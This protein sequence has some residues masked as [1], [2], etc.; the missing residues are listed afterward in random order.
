MEDNI[1][2]M[3]QKVSKEVDDFIENARKKGEFDPQD[4]QEVSHKVFETFKKAGFTKSVHP[5][6][7]VR[8]RDEQNEKLDN[9]VKWIGEEYKLKI[10]SLGYGNNGEPLGLL[11]YLD[12][13]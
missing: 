13:K 10:R 11:I 7:G 12:K 9:L 3:M 1:I 5:K 6:D 4:Y 2:E 8:W